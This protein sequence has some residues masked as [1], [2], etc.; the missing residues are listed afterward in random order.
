MATHLL[1]KMK[2]KDLDKVNDDFSDFSL[3]SPARKIRRLDAELPPIVE[4]EE[5]EISLGFGL[6]Q[7]QIR[8]PNGVEARLTPLIIEELPSD[9]VP[10]NEERAIVPFRPCESPLY[11]R[12]PNYSIDSTLFSNFKNQALW[13]AQSRPVIIEE[14]E[15]EL[16]GNS[17]V[18]NECLAVIPWVPSQKLHQSPEVEASQREMSESM[19]A[20]VMESTSMDI[21]DNVASIG[22]GQPSECN[23]PAGS[24][25]GMQHLWQQQHCMIPQPPQNT[26]SPIVWYR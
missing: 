18:T 23:A 10:V 9:S 20:E 21:E 17:A 1:K 6:S 12:P 3:S 5:T 16:K 24:N 13:H 11:H 8:I 4:E 25:E 14:D 7:H 22:A 2:R 26:I 19:D 15:E